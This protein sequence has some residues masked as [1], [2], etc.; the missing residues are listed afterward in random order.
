MWFKLSG[1][2]VQPLLVSSVSSGQSA[3]P[4]LYFHHCVEEIFGPLSALCQ[5]QNNDY[6][7]HDS[8]VSVRSLFSVPTLVYYLD[9]KVSS[10]IKSLKI[11]RS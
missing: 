8:V 2:E 10:T 5:P 6:F 3:H 9:S 7:E 11:L 1:T 4:L